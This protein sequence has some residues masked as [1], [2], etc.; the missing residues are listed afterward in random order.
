MTLYRL[1][2]KRWQSTDSGWKNHLPLAI[3]VPS[4][5]PFPKQTNWNG[6]LQQEHFVFW[7]FSLTF[8]KASKKNVHTRENFRE[9][10]ICINKNS[11]SKLELMTESLNPCSTRIT[12]TLTRRNK[13]ESNP[14]QRDCGLAP[15]KSRSEGEVPYR[16]QAEGAEGGAAG[17]V[18]T[19]HAATGSS[20]PSGGGVGGGG[21]SPQPRQFAGAPKQAQEPNQPNG[22]QSGNPP[23][24]N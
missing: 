24:K 6:H 10:A 16:N 18:A 14:T 20:P 22:R 4:L 15:P 21:P 8:R 12:K 23:P 7:H 13:F 5:L 2:K 17:R 3:A 11:D 1:W 19:S 9:Q